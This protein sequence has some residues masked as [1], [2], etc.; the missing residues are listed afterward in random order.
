MSLAAGESLRSMRPLPRTMPAR[1]S[2][3]A[4]NSE[5]PSKALSVVPVR[6]YQRMAATAAPGMRGH[7][8]VA[9]CRLRIA[10]IFIRQAHTRTW[11]HMDAPEGD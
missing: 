5:N 1:N 7:A 10:R 11:N 6:L 9:S 4:G 2:Y 8:S 3:S